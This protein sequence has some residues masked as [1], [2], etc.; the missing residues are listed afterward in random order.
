[1]LYDTLRVDADWSVDAS[2]QPGDVFSLQ[3]PPE[4]Q[5]NGGD[6]FPLETTSLQPA[7]SCTAVPAQLPIPARID[8]ILSDYVA[9]RDFVAGKLWFIVN[10]VTVTESTTVVF[11]LESG[12]VAIP[13]PGG[14]G[15]VPRPSPMPTE[16]QKGGFVVPGNEDVIAWK[17]VAPGDQVSGAG[18]LVIRDVYANDLELISDNPSFPFLVHSMPRTQEAWEA[19]IWDPITAATVAFDPENHEFRV[20]IPGPIDPNR[21]YEVFYHTR[22]VVPHFPGDTFSNSASFNGIERTGVVTL[23]ETGGGTGSGIPRG[24]ITLEKRV[25][26]GAPADIRY[27]VRAEFTRFG[28]AETRVL[29]L[30]PGSAPESL[31]NLPAGTEVTLSE[32]PPEGATALPW[33]T[34]LFQGNGVVDHGDGTATVT[35][36]ADA[37]IDILLINS[38]LPLE[39]GSGGL[40]I[41]KTVT[42]LNTASLAPGATFTVG[43]SYPAGEGTSTGT[44]TLARDGS[45]VLEGLPAGTL[46]TLHEAPTAAMTSSSGEAIAWGTPE[47]RIAGVAQGATA[48]VAIRAESTVQ[49]D[50]VNPAL[51]TPT[52]AGTTG[53]SATGT[54]LG[55]IAPALGAALLLLL[56]GA[57]LLRRRARP[58]QTH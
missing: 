31:N 29:T 44:L 57:L 6:P 13:L 9:G 56:G 55:D 37:H 15:I 48:T 39:P 28:V 36:I 7:G 10:A 17:L 38:L 50:L 43:Y 2:A 51:L 8:C 46:V 40:R 54:S 49:V 11:G 1:M 24:G 20:S 18:D 26:G 34:P 22:I 52:G 33:N 42:G 41:T 16:I 35:V 32:Q 25:L 27:T 23:S 14:S 53:L 5:V 58:A 45:A 21:F 3:L 47:F 4:F 30:I 19:N 12:S